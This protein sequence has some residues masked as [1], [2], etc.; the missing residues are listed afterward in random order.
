M[1]NLQPYHLAC[2]CFIVL[3]SW[4][5]IGLVLVYLEVRVICWKS[6]CLVLVTNS[7]VEEDKSFLYDIGLGCYISEYLEFS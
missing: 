2:Q 3:T 4:W 6:L 7:G 1:Y 5:M